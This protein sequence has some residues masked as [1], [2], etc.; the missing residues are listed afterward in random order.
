MGCLLPGI[1]RRHLTWMDARVGDRPVTPRNGKPVEIQALWYNAL[2]F[3]GRL[4][5]DFGDDAAQTLHEDLAKNAAQ[6]FDRTFWNEHAGLSYAMLSM[7]A[8]RIF[9]CARTR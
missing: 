6:N 2:R 8:C 4:A 3:V 9:R 1:H 7:A 5:Q